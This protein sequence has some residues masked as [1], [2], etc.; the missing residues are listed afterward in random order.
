[1]LHIY[2][3]LCNMLRDNLKYLFYAKNQISNKHMN[4]CANSLIF[5]KIL[6]KQQYHFWP[7][8]GKVYKKS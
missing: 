8:L 3:M 2:D 4:R 7:E 1:M 6:N 5:G